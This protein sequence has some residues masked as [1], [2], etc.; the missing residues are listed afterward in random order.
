[1][2]ERGIQ[3]VGPMVRAV[4][5]GRKSVTRRVISPQPNIDPGEFDSATVNAAWQSGHVDVRCPYGV[6]GDRLWVR[7][8]WAYFGGAE[9]LYQRD[10]SMVVY[11]ATRADDLRVPEWAS[12]DEPGCDGGR[13]RPSIFMPRWASRITLEITEVRVERVQDISEEDAVAEGIEEFGT[14]QRSWISGSTAL[15][16]LAGIMGAN[17]ALSR[18]GFLASLVASG[19]IALGA[20]GKAERATPRAAFGHLWE[21]IHGAGAWERNDWVWVVRFRRVGA[22]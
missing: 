17:P 12:A 8:T 10:P 11:K 13:W 4:L 14:V 3:F 16:A 19:A 18:R 2:R 5:D 21:S 9:Y 1:M 7:E 6:H 22:A 15:G 20:D